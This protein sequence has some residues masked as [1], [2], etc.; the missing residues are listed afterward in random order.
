MR[1]IVASQRVQLRDRGQTLGRV[2]LSIGVAEFR[3]GERCADWIARADAALYEAKHQG[4]NRVVAATGPF[5]L[6]AG[7][8]LLALAQRGVAASS[9]AVC[10]AQPVGAGGGRQRWATDQG[11]DGVAAK[12]AQQLPLGL[13]TVGHDPPARP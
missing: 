5:A 4:R 8:Q 1:E 9:A 12:L 10:L 13:G 11:L 7:S 2:T 6:P 3:G